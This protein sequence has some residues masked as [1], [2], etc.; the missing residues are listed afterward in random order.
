MQAC[1]D[2]LRHAFALYR[3]PYATIHHTPTFS[4]QMTAAAVHVPGQEMAKTVV[5]EGKGQ[6]YLAVL[7][8]SYRV[9]LDR[10][11]QVVG[12]PVHLATEEKIRDLFPDCELGAIPPFGP[13]YGVPVFVDVSLALD[14]EIVF[15]AG[16]HC[17]AVRMNYQ[18]FESLSRPEVCSFGVRQEG[19]RRGAV[20]KQGRKHA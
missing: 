2:R 14:R 19:R 4:S 11:S 15:A 8:A 12:E 16:T 9:D 7:P 17:D 6:S 1:S 5:L 10:F 18:D 20:P 13:L 3:I